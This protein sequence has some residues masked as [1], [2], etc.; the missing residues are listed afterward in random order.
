MIKSAPATSLNNDTA[1]TES[2]KSPAADFKPRGLLWA[3]YRFFRQKKCIDK[4]QRVLYNQGN[5]Q[6][7]NDREEVTL[8]DFLSESRRLVQAGGER[9]GEYILGA[10]A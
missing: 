10:A 3:Y 4:H 7:G 2:D 6:K 8:H 9:A 1:S 5:L